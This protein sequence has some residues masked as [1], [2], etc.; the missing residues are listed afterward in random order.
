M[1]ACD[2]TIYR[3]LRFYSDNG[4]EYWAGLGGSFLL[5]PAIEGIFN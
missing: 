1:V 2:F 4:L 3:F 5:P